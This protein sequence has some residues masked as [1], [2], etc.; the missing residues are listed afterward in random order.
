MFV[1]FPKFGTKKSDSANGP[2]IHLF[3]IHSTVGSAADRA[4]LVSIFCLTEPYTKI[5]LDRIQRVPPVL[6]FTRVGI[7]CSGEGTS[8]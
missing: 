2:S 4:A 3:S 6:E 7:I 5:G 8:P 1:R